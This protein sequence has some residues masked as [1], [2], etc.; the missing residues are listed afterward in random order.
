MGG[1]IGRLGGEG[2]PQGEVSGEQDVT[3]TNQINR[4]GQAGTR[5]THHQSRCDT[6]PGDAAKG[7]ARHDAAVLYALDQT[8]M[9][10]DHDNKAYVVALAAYDRE[11]SRKT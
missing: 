9:A 5:P 6:T 2:C 8:L 7:M 3:H 1:N 4:K 11:V 10:P